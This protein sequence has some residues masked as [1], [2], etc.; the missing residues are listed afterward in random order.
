MKK[1]VKLHK[2]ARYLVEH[3]GLISWLSS[4]LSFFSERLSGD[5][6]SF[7]LKQLTIV[8]EVITPFSTLFSLPLS[9]CR[10]SL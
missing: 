4:A 1:S 10:F 5:Q 6:R 3:C 9:M 2:M 8:T 7:W